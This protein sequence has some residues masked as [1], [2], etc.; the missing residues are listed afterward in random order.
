M[1]VGLTSISGVSSLWDTVPTLTH[2]LSGTHEGLFTFMWFCPTVVKI[3]QEKVVQ[4][5]RSKQNMLSSN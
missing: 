4:M 5:T 3:L 1:A 2:M